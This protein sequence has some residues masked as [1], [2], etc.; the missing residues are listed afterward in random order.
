MNGAHRVM[1]RLSLIAALVAA[2][3]C[4]GSTPAVTPTPVPAPDP[5]MDSRVGLKAG[6][7]DA[8]EAVSN[9]RIAA[10]AVSPPGFLGITNSDMAF[11][12]NYVIQGNY[13]G[14]VIWDVSNPSK[15]QL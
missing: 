8:G 7:M 6:L 1:P 4:A 3:G 13:N 11:T 10:K 12:G 9:L 2:A 14:P 15:P 5:R